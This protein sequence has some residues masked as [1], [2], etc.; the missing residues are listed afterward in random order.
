MAIVKTENNEGV[1][2]LCGNGICESDV[3]TAPIVN[4]VEDNVVE[5]NVEQVSSMADVNDED[6]ALAACATDD[7]DDTNYLYYPKPLL[8][9]LEE[10]V[11]L[12]TMYVPGKELSDSEKMLVTKRLTLFV[13]ELLN[14]A[15][16]CG[17]EDIF[18]ASFMKIMSVYMAKTTIDERKYLLDLFIN[19]KEPTAIH[20]YAGGILL[21]RGVISVKDIYDNDDDKVETK[22]SPLS[23][24]D[25]AFQKADSE[26]EK[27]LSAIETENEAKMK[28]LKKLNE[29]KPTGY[30][31]GGN[32]SN[33]GISTLGIVGIGLGAVAVGVA[34]YYGY[35]CFFGDGCDN[36]DITL[37]D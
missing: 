10:V 36:D 20:N 14:I 23:K 6:T 7:K 16:D 27:S 9:K 35:N 34:A 2:E 37:I 25:E 17:K 24:L 15:I 18:T 4:E 26:I 8:E 1:D 22:K 11:T 3:N 29:V 30:T 12:D 5:D 32:G 21:A 33:D 13:A 19:Q 28:E 31:G